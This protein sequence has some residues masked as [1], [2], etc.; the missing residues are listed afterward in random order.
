MKHSNH[1]ISNRFVNKFLQIK[2]KSLPIQV[3]KA[4][5]MKTINN[6]VFSIKQAHLENYDLPNRG[7]FW[8]FEFLTTIHLNPSLSCVL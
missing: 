3:F 7:R 5:A 1:S 2:I 8:L 4:R 6:F